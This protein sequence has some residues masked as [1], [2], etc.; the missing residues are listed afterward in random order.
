MMNETFDEM[1]LNSKSCNS[2]TLLPFIGVSFLS[3]SNAHFD[4]LEIP[5]S[6]V[7]HSIAIWDGKRPKRLGIVQRE[8]SRYIQITNGLQ[9]F[10]RTNDSSSEIY[11]LLVTWAAVKLELN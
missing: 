8:H 3:I 6:D 10:Y 9:E 1:L 7:I 4:L 5:K 2:F 11:H